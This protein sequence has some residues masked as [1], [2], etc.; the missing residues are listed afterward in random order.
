MTLEKVPDLASAR[1]PDVVALAE[2]ILESARAGEITGLV[3]AY[4]LATGGGGYREAH[5]VGAHPARLVGELEAAKIA[6]VQRYMLPEG[7]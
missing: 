7:T 6:I 1:A 2:Q 3:V 5:G 4:E